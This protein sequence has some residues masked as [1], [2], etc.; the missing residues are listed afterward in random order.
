MTKRSTKMT[1]RPTNAS[2]STQCACVQ[3]SSGSLPAY[4]CK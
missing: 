2:A 3:G 4:F 1:K